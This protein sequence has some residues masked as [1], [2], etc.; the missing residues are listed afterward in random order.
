MV[1]RAETPQPKERSKSREKAPPSAQGTGARGRP[2][3]ASRGRGGRRRQSQWKE[4]LYPFLAILLLLPV[5]GG[6]WLLVPD[7]SGGHPFGHSLGVVG[8]ILMVMT[9]TL[10]PFRK[11][12]RWLPKWVGS[13]RAWLSFH[14]FTGI[15]GP[16]LVLIHTALRFNGLAGV[17]AGLTAAVVL[18]GF[19]G[20]YI[21]VAVPRTKSGLVRQ[22][23]ELEK[24]ARALREEL[25]ESPIPT[26]V[27]E[28]I[29]RLTHPVRL[30]SAEVLLR[31]VDDLRIRRRFRQLLREVDPEVRP[32]LAALRDRVFAYAVL[33]RQI[34]TLEA[35]QGLLGLWHLFHVPLGVSLFTGVAL[36]ILV[37]LYYM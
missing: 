18:S 12:A 8:T 15:V 13:V 22:R 33:Q 37:A 20:R 6:Y 21:Y 26:P 4:L 28:E 31:I 34:A 2:S 27:M 1:Q 23:A 24:E 9:E 17:V 19:V 5:W 32:R 16:F 35:A 36:H 29:W 30:P 11:R 7:M 14:I 10:Y 25:E 3:R